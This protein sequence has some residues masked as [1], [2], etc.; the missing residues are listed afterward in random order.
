MEF[1]FTMLTSVVKEIVLSKK[2]HVL[3]TDK[4]WLSKNY[5]A[6]TNCFLKIGSEG[7]KYYGHAKDVQFCVL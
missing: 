4:H 2:S 1:V 5:L 3:E 6:A 7:T